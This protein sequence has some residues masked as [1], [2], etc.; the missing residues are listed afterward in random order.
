MFSFLPV[1]IGMA[2]S[3]A[4]ALAGQIPLRGEPSRCADLSSSFIASDGRDAFR[5]FYS[6][7]PRPL[8]LIPWKCLGPNRRALSR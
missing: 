6:C 8:S 5:R 2:A 7:S 1:M 4:T 3:L